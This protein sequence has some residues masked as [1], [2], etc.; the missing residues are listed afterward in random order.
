MRQV[1][2]YRWEIE[3]AVCKRYWEGPRWRWAIKFCGISIVEDETALQTS[4]KA[5]RLYIERTYY[6]SLFHKN[7]GDDDAYYINFHSHCI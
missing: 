1:V 6:I 7:L 2:M 5:V 3:A 4:V